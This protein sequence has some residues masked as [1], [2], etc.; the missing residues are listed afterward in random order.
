MTHPTY[1]SQECPT[2]GRRLRVRVQYLGKAVICQ[3][4]HGRFEAF[5]S[6][7]APPLPSDS[8]L[9]L[10]DRANELLSSAKWDA[11]YERGADTFR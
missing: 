6:E 11:E 2:C 4:C 1:F 3:H 8:G 7:N 10:L 5:D 9:S